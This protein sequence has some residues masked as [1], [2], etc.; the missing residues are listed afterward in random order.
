MPMPCLLTENPKDYI[1]EHLIFIMFAVSQFFLPLLSFY[2]MIFMLLVVSVRKHQDR[3]AELHF[4]IEL[5]IYLNYG[6][7]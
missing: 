1:A 3:V 6:M 7:C 2:G 5:R 4:R